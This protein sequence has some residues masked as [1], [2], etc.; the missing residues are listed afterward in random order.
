M[1]GLACFSPLVGLVGLVGALVATNAR[2][3][4][5]EEK[6]QCIN[7]SD[8]GQ[9]L[10]DDGKYKLAREAF[11]RC[12]RGTC[13]SLVSHDCAQWLVDVDTRSPTVVVDAKDDKGNDLV[14]VKVDVDGAEFI[15]KLDGLPRP[16]DPGERVFRYETAGFPPVE[17][18]VVI[19]T[20]EKNRV[21]KVRFAL[22]QSPPATAP[23]PE[24]S[25]SL[26]AGPPPLAAWVFAGVAAAA[27]VSETYFGLSGLSQRSQDL[28]PPP[29]GC[30][31]HCAPS[32]KSSIQTKFAIAD[33]S[34]G[35]GIV[36]AGLAAYFFLRP[37]PQ[38]VRALP[39]AAVDFTPRPGGGLATVSG[40]F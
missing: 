11:V 29:G 3:A 12:A 39:G 6:T 32:E 38:P 13:P 28:G 5:P 4:D 26:H 8:E 33:V 23:G 31:G 25:E 7:A 30:A 10:R 21:L 14:D 15:A 18:H 16:V 9:Q 27:L 20:G 2:A 34:L 35:V 36:S 40:H 37:R 1:R 17:E 24:T 22:D 19:R